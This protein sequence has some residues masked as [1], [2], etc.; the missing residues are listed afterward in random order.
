MIIRVCPPAVSVRLLY[1]I[2]VR[3]SGWSGPVADD[4]GGLSGRTTASICLKTGPI[5]RIPAPTVG[6]LH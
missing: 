5:G 4:A 2:F 6:S 3:L 1:L